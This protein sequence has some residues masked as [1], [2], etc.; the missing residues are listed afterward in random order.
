MLCL[1]VN[2]IDSSD[3]LVGTW[4]SSPVCVDNSGLRR[5]REEAQAGASVRKPSFFNLYMHFEIVRHRAGSSSSKKNGLLIVMQ[6]IS[7]AESSL[8]SGFQL[9]ASDF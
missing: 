8:A 6:P 3:A 5:R 1:F 2:S 4:S 7:W 9:L